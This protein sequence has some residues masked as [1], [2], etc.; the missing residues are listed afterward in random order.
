MITIAFK[1][2]IK[3]ADARIESINLQK[4]PQQNTELLKNCK[5]TTDITI[6]MLTA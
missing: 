4:V 3:S 1:E 5:V 6:H 2:A